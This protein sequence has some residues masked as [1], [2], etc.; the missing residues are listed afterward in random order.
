MKLKQRGKIKD[1]IPGAFF[2]K[3]LAVFMALSPFYVALV[4]SFKSKQD[5]AYTGLAL[6]S[7]LDLSNYIEGIKIAN[8][9]TALKN[10]VITTV[11]TVAILILVTSLSSYI[12]ARRQK[13]RFFTICYYAF[14]GSILVP[15]QSIMFPLY[16]NLR[17]AGL[18]NSLSGYIIARAGFLIAYNTL[19]MTGFV[20]SVPLEL[21]EAALIDG[22]GPLKTFWLIVFPLMK[23][24]VA[25]SLIINSLYTWNDFIISV[26]ILQRDFVRTLP[27]TQFY[28]FGEN[29]VELGMAFA[30]LILSMIPIIAVYLLMQKYIVEGITMGGVKG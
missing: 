11:G 25:T 14:L 7:S 20:K 13:S 9:F 3:A 4:F 8:F 15:F 16:M 12:I 1:S 19:L 30:V 28:F 23:P 2:I 21:E 5:I 6:P 18:I 29:S 27:L 24:I 10:S 22:A 26:I 17:S